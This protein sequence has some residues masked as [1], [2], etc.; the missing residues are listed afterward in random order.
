MVIPSPPHTGER[1]IR[2]LRMK[3]AIETELKLAAAPEA[4]AQLL[5]DSDLFGADAITRDQVSTY[6]DTAGL[7]L[8]EAGLSLRIR[9]IGDR[10]VQTIKAESAVAASLFAREEWE[11]DVPGDVPVLDP[12]TIPLPVLP[13]PWP[14]TVAPVF[15]AEVSRTATVRAAGGSRVEIVADRGRIIGGGRDEPISEF[16]LELLQGDPRALFVLARD[17]AGRA[18]LR[19]GVRSKSERGYALLA[20]TD[21]RAVKAEPIRLTVDMD[22]AALF[23]A[24]ASACLRHF[25]LNEDLLL[26]TG[27]PEPLHQA[28][29]ALRRLRSALTIFKDMLAGPEFDRF[30]AELRWISALLG[31]VRNIDVLM[32]QI[33]EGE[34][35][36]GLLQEARARAL[37]E[38]RAGLDSPRMRTLI[39]DLVEWTTV[40]AWRD[41]PALAALRTIPARIYAH[42][43]LDRFRRRLKKEGRHLAR[44]DEEHRHEVRI[45]AKK[46]RYAAEFF[47][48]LFP[49]KKAGRRRE[50]FLGEI[51]RLQ[52]ALGELND[53]ASGRLLLARLGVADGEALLSGGKRKPPAKLLG[54]AEDAYEGLIDGKRFWR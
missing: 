2:V 17:L 29:V 33:D 49:G 37:A 36:F 6:F 52:T 42:D 47:A 18:P 22:A 15:T 48:A 27:R 45:T 39:L 30:R 16:E 9:R 20:G 8:H 21:A 14:D 25:R 7:A 26:A 35:A 53:V 10:R 50:R 13:E 51:E 23:A 40:G 46:L 19:L 31:E 3:S 54:E 44:L 4:I 32:S 34:A 28:R 38:L 43:K 11:R 1:Q 12:G 5:A 24:V 41:D